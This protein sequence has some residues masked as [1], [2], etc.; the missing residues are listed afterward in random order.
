[1]TRI[2]KPFDCD[3]FF[4]GAKSEKSTVFDWNV[5][6][7]SYVSKTMVSPDGVPFDHVVFTNPGHKPIHLPYPAHE[8]YQYLTTIRD[9]INHGNQRGDR[10]GTGTLSKFGV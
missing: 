7:I 4:P 1:M 10:T 2:A 3:V 8:E 9:L 5:F 6:P